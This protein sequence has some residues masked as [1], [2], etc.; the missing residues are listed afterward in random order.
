MSR[1]KQYTIITG[2]PLI[3][4][5]LADNVNY[6]FQLVTEL[7]TYRLPFKDFVNDF[8]SIVVHISGCDSGASV[9]YASFECVGMCKYDD[10][11]VTSTSFVLCM[12]A[13]SA[14]EALVVFAGFVT[15]ARCIL[16][17]LFLPEVMAFCFCFLFTVKQVY[18]C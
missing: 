16:R 5:I 17:R 3:I 15:T 11:S 2:A 12:R 8:F 10:V 1:I 4:A 9:F 13:C 7:I 18:E 14:A 6:I